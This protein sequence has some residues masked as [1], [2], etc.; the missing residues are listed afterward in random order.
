MSHSNEQLEA[1]LFRCPDTVLHTLAHLTGDRLGFNGLRKRISTVKDVPQSENDRRELIK[2]IIRELRYFGSNNFAY[3]GRWITR[4]ERGVSYHTVVYDVSR[5]LNRHAKKKIE[6]PRVAAVE[7]RERMICGQLLG[8]IFEDKTDEQIATMLEEAGLGADSTRPAA[9]KAAIQAGGG[10][11]LLAL[12]KLLGVSG[13]TQLLS[14]VAVKIVAKQIGKEAAEQLI[15]IV[16]EKV[17]EKAFSRLLGWIGVLLIVK[18]IIDLASPGLR[19][20]IPAVS[21][22]AALRQTESLREL[23]SSSQKKGKGGLKAVS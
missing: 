10:G 22:I 5:A 11:L 15:K 3:L 23:K 17:P 1:F 7:D 13:V 16:A 2:T 12:T 20:T 4:R 9:I 14:A 21:L 8:M 19:V 18:D 6:L